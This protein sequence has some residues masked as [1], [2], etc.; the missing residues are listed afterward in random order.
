M[1]LINAICGFWLL[2]EIMINIFTRTRKPVRGSYDKN[3]LGMIWVVIVL[4]ITC[5]VLIASYFP[6]FNIYR[7]FAGLF[8]IVSGMIIRFIAIVSLKSMFTP[9]VTIQRDHVLK[10]NGIF[11]NVRHPSY[12]GS[13]LSFLGLGIA[14]GNWISLLVIFVPVCAVFLYRINVEEQALVAS[15]G[16]DYVN[17]Q[18]VTKKLIPYIY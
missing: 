12:T 15:F 1:W 5:G 16:Q 13:L 6:E 8:L 9:N 17:Y 2:S 4:S 7:Y 18:K 11:K 14:L 10:T 3:T